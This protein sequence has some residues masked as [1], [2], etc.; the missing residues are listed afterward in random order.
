MKLQLGDF[1]VRLGSSP[2]EEN[3]FISIE[4]QISICLL[5]VGAFAE[6]FDSALGFYMDLCKAMRGTSESCWFELQ[7]RTRKRLPNEIVK[8]VNV[9]G[10]TQKGALYGN[11]GSDEI[12]TLINEFWLSDR[13]RIIGTSRVAAGT[14]VELVEA[15]DNSLLDKDTGTNALPTSIMFVLEKCYFAAEPFLVLLVDNAARNSTRELVSR[16]ATRLHRPLLEVGPGA[17]PPAQ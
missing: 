2:I 6:Q 1:F 8:G 17:W 9:V 15:L 11:L 5:R 13:F 10:Y 12:I 3:N 4:C 16:A 7:R 14:A